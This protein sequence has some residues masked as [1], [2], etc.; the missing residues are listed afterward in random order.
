MQPQFVYL[1]HDLQQLGM[2][3]VDAPLT[4]EWM[5]HALEGLEVAPAG[6]REGRVR[7]RLVTTGR[8]V[9][10]RGTVS[11]PVT[12][13]CGRCL[14]SMPLDIEADL[15]LLL[16]PEK[17]AAPPKTPRGP[18]RG[19]N[20]SV[21]AHQP[22]S[23]TGKGRWHRDDGDEVYEF[24]PDE[25]DADT[26]AGDEVVLDGFIREAIVLEIP[27]F[28]LCSEQCPGIGPVPAAPGDAD[29]ADPPI[30]P[31]LAPLL[32]LKKES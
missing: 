28:P 8:D 7:L 16:M 3:D 24:S 21:T 2:Q 22:S 18:K 13:T 12:T 15:S 9:V 20:E 6:D 11:A 32:A 5:S 1:I 14:R 25:A 17:V 10:V 31:R 27:I 26:Y 23:K 4:R 30:D 29:L 19:K